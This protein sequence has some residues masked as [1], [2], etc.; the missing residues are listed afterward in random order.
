M[1]RQRREKRKSESPPRPTV[2]AVDQSLPALVD[3]QEAWR[4]ALIAGRRPE[5]S[6]LPVVRCPRCKRVWFVEVAQYRLV[7]REVYAPDR[8]GDAAPPRRIRYKVARCVWCN[9]LCELPGDGPPQY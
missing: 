3:D 9:Q 2:R 6:E 1:K 5:P 8:I 7:P 4:G